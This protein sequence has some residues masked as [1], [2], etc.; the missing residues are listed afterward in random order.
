[1]NLRE[2]KFKF[3]DSIVVFN[4]FFKSHD[5]IAVLDVAFDELI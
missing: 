3:D 5:G 1:V 4:E 2:I